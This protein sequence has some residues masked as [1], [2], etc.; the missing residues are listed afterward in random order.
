LVVGIV[1]RRRSAGGWGTVVVEELLDFSHFGLE[2]KIKEGGDQETKEEAESSSSK[3]EDGD[4]NKEKKEDKEEE[5]DNDNDDDDGGG[6]LLIPVIK[7][8]GG[9]IPRLAGAGNANKG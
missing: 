5:D 7:W 3:D 2:K 8:I 9:V 4:Q 6:G 1:A